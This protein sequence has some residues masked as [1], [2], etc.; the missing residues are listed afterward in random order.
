MDPFMNPPPMDA[1]IWITLIACIF[2][3]VL[4]QK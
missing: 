3:L 2:G 4:A 1:T